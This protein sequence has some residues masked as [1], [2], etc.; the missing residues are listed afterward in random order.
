M[1]PEQ[2][3]K[4]VPLTMDGNLYRCVICD[5]NDVMLTTREALLTVIKIIPVT[6]DSAAVA[7]WIILV[8][9]GVGILLC[10]GV[11]GRKGRR[12]RP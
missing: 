4:S 3:L 8:L 10:L 12:N 2:N 6:G 5:D 11:T 7:E 1:N 9:L